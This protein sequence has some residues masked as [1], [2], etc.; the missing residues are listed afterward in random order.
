MER[1]VKEREKRSA[2]I[3]RRSS[4]ALWEHVR[5]ADDDDDD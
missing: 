5:H 2:L 4:A 1:G 3:T